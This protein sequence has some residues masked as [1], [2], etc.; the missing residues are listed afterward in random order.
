MTQQPETVRDMSRGIYSRLMELVEQ[1]LAQGASTISVYG[2]IE[3]VRM[4]VETG[5]QLSLLRRMKAREAAE[6]KAKTE[7]KETP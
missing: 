3:T 1:E 5:M 4:T 2:A 6:A 7:P